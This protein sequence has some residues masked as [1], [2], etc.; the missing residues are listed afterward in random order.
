MNSKIAELEYRLSEKAPS[1]LPSLY[2]SIGMGN[3]LSSSLIKQ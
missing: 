2:H 3:S 1:I